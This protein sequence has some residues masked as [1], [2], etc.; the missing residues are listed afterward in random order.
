M[1]RRSSDMGTKSCPD[2]GWWARMEL[3]SKFTSAQRRR[4]WI[5]WRDPACSAH[6]K[7]LDGAKQ[8]G[9]LT[10]DEY[11]AQR[12]ILSGAAQPSRAQ[13]D[14]PSPR[15]MCAHFR[16]GDY[17]VR[18]AVEG[19]LWRAGP[20]HVAAPE[21]EVGFARSHSGQV[22]ALVSSSR[23]RRIDAFHRPAARDAVV[24]SERFALR[25]TWRCQRP[26]G[27]LIV[28]VVTIEPSAGTSALIHE[29]D[30]GLLR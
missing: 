1:V 23:T 6:L 21:Q 27:R 18:H 20:I 8:Q 13:S 15:R 26:S 5:R 28:E 24:K 3:A 30:A 9:L 19:V 7:D 4:N 12:T 22:R 2:F 10:K 11:Q 29:L 25:S 14:E 16:T 17:I